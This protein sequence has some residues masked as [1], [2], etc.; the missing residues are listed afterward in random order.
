M[1]MSMSMLYFGTTRQ[2]PLVDDAHD[3]HAVCRLRSTLDAARRHWHHCTTGSELD[4]WTAIAPNNWQR[5]APGPCERQRRV[6]HLPFAPPSPSLPSLSLSRAPSP[7][8]YLRMIS[9]GSAHLSHAPDAR[10]GPRRASLSGGLPSSPRLRA[11]HSLASHSL[12]SRS[13]ASRISSLVSPS[14]RVSN[15]PKLPRGSGP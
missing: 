2:S 13:L 8:P 7:S 5:P 11:S 14:L 4:R 9:S 12:A 10:G 6:C 3:T 15:R 1:S